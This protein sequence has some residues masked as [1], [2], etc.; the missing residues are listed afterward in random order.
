MIV[1]NR[2]V[3]QVTIIAKRNGK[4]VKIQPLITKS[5]KSGDCDCDVNGGTP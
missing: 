3:K 2:N 1:V 5:A 4:E